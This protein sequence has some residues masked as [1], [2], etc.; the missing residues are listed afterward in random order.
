MLGK[1]S[2]HHVSLNVKNLE[3]SKNFYQNI[4][5][6]KELERPNFG[7][8]G[9]WYEIGSQQ[10]HLIVEGDAYLEKSND[11]NS[12]HDHFAIRVESYFNTLAYLKEKKL[13]VEENPMSASGF[14]QIF[15]KDP[16]GNLIEFHVE[17]ESYLKE[18]EQ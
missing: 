13:E 7:F 16:D 12:K 10:L 9:A 17:R 14:A 8:P 4:I 2:L 1:I 5:G 11:L 18:K 6:L 3:Q 15:C